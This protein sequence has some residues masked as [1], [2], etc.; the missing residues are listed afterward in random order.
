MKYI[1][2]GPFLDSLASNPKAPKPT[3]LIVGV[4]ILAGFAVWQEIR[5]HRLNAERNSLASL[6]AQK[7]SDANESLAEVPQSK[8]ETPD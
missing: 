2:N 1:N 5:M 8:L 7:P 4:I 6:L 3:L